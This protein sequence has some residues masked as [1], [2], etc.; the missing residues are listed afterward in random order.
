VFN[1]VVIFDDS[2][3]QARDLGKWN[4]F[5]LG[6]VSEIPALAPVVRMAEGED[7]TRPTL[8]HQ[9]QSL[10]QTGPGESE[11]CECK[12]LWVKMDHWMEVIF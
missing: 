10:G 8:S 4:W 6:D 9:P 12:S 5:E 2:F 7:A 3:S 1:E 11:T